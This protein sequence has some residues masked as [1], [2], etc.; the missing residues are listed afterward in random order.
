MSDLNVGIVGLGWVAEAH[1]E[2]FKAVNGATVSAIC[3]RRAHEPSD[4]EAKYG[5]SLKPYQDYQAMLDDPELDVIDICTP[6]GHHADQAVLAAEAG[7]HLIIEKPAALNWQDAKRIQA[8]VEKAGVQASVCF[9]GRFAGQFSLA[10]S[11]IDHGLLGDIHYAEVDYFHGIGPKTRQFSWN[12]KR[13][14]GG[15][16]LL[17]AGCHAL[18]MLL[19]L[20]DSPVESVTSLSTNSRNADFSAYE[21]DTTIVTLLRFANGSLGKVASVIDSVQPYYFHSHIVGS[22]GSLLDN[23]FY[24]NKFEGLESKRWTELETTSLASGDRADH[25]YIP[26]FQAF[27]DGVIQGVPMPRTDLATAL[28]S[29]RVIFA[30]DQSAAER[31]TVAL[32]ELA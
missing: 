2:A 21:Y 30:A 22:S 29:H 28:E 16:S 13:D 23:K 11:V 31:R 20:V 4:L 27:V 14:L 17:T 9:E 1:I 25:P 24:S 8:A 12:T 7:K 15:S 18:D 6:N 32:E 26:M 5:L 10:R 3:S 19:F